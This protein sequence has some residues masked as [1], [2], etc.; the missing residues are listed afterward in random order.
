MLAADRE[1]SR[2][3][4]EISSGQPGRRQSD[5]RDR[6]RALKGADI[7]ARGAGCDPRQRRGCLTR[8]EHD[9]RL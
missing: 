7:K 6:K 8:L 2:L 3:F 5:G 9:A 4:C 1:A